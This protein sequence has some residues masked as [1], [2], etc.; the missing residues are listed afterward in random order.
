MLLFD[1][2]L[3]GFLLNDRLSRFSSSNYISMATNDESSI[4]T[5]D[6]TTLSQKIQSKEISCIQLMKTTL[7]RVD[8]VNQKV[9]NAIFSIRDRE[10]LLQEARQADA[11]NAAS[12]RGWLHGIPMAIK[13]LA[14]VAGIPTTK[15]GSALF[16]GYVPDKSD[17]FVQ[18][19]Q[20]EGAIII[21]KTN[22]PENGLG[23]HTFNSK[24][25]VTKNPFD[26]TKS[27]GGSSGGAAVA[28]ATNCVCVADGTDMMGSLRNPA[29]WNHLYSH[30][31][32]AGIMGDVLPNSYPLS[33]PIS[34]AG[35]M[36]RS[37]QDVARLLE[38]MVG[39][40]SKFQ[41]KDLVSP[42]SIRIGW[43]GD[44]NGAFRM[45]EGVLELCESALHKF[46][47]STEGVDIVI[48]KQIE[49]PF[50]SEKLWES[51]TTIRSKV[52]ADSALAE[53]PLSDLDEV[54]GG[55]KLR[56]ILPIKPEGLWE[57]QRGMK[58]SNEDVCAA[59]QVANEWIDCADT[60]FAKRSVDV[61]ALP[62][63]QLFPFPCEWDWPK[64]IRGR[65]MDTYHRWM[66]VVVPC[67]LGG[68]PCVTIPAGFGPLP[69]GIQLFGPKHSD[70]K[71]LSIASLY[72]KVMRFE[73]SKYRQL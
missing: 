68:F 55:N 1:V 71:L 52:T 13:D 58:L 39:D 67:S 18:R 15:G 3:I 30:R 64:E 25:G 32:T 11:D 42:T 4:L 20:D 38:T 8:Q 21:G 36:G 63:A 5:L 50:P 27:A 37:P 70:A 62:T 26:L 16:D 14:N 57:I 40:K 66:E 7:D 9:G 35:P 60:I 46:A 43:C 10:E 33:Y 48:D 56:E 29:G 17:P 65:E 12:Q 61:F 73:S 54:P 59:V 22:T 53:P 41:Y 19:L 45:E 28:L 69:M 44:W 24:W 34:T 31:P 47:G 51:W 6:A 2:F 49:A 72:N 23:S